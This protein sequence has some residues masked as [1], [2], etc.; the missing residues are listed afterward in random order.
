MDTLENRYESRDDLG[1]AANGRMLAFAIPTAGIGQ[2]SIEDAAEAALWQ[3]QPEP[4][5][6]IVHS[7]SGWG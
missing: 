4:T 5:H 1:G 2:G 6:R 3:E 7:L